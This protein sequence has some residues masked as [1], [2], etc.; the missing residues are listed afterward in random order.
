MNKIC[1]GVAA[2]IIVLCAGSRAHAQNCEKRA[3]QDARSK[4][5]AKVWSAVTSYL[6]QIEVP[7]PDIR[8][9]LDSEVQA[10]LHQRNEKR[11]NLVAANQYY[12]ANELQKQYATT[13]QNIEASI[14]AESVAAQVIYLS[15]VI[16]RYEDLSRAFESYVA[17]DARRTPRVLSERVVSGAEMFLPLSKSVL[18]ETLQCG[19]R[20]MREPEKR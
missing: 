14:S 4:E 3:T 6:D 1:V 15:V 19:V 17:F 13:R 5:I 8:A 9:Y 16:N 20:Q 10:A 18:L 12:R 11:F 2:A 7:P